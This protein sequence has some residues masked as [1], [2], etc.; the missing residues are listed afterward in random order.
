MNGERDPLVDAKSAFDRLKLESEI[1]DAKLTISAVARLAKVDRKY[2][3]GKINTPDESK[4]QAWVALGEEINGFRS[5]QKNPKVVCSE[6]TLARKLENALIENYR[7]LESVA[8]LERTRAKM[9]ELLSS[10]EKLT[11]SS[12]SFPFCLKPRSV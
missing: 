1:S 10:K 5:R 3:Y 2:F 8:D 11:S 12:V 7:L 9:Q 4:R 6:I